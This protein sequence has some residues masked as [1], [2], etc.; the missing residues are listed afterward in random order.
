MVSTDRLWCPSDRTDVSLVSSLADQSWYPTDSFSYTFSQWTSSPS[1]D[2]LRV[3]YNQ[4]YLY[5]KVYGSYEDASSYLSF[6]TDTRTISSLASPALD[7]EFLVR[8]EGIA[9][10]GAC[11]QS[12]F[13]ISNPC[14]EN[15]LRKSGNGL[16]D[17]TY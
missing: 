7:D 13:T 5:R 11:T 4:I 15:E 1:C 16:A 9:N 17:Q 14:R 10:D 12:S 8:V 2:D 3:D 6:D